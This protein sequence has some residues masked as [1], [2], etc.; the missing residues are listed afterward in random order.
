MPTI[1]SLIAKLESAKKQIATKRDKLRELI[2]EAEGPE[3][4]CT[5]AIESIE[6]P[7]DALSETL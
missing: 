6:R 1:K 4:N 2:S 7:A 5:E 3:E